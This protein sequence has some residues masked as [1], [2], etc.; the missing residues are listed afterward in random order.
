MKEASAYANA[1]AQNTLANASFGGFTLYDRST[2]TEDDY[3][4]GPAPSV[5]VVLR[6]EFGYVVAFGGAGMRETD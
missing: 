3:R 5:T 1:I 2:L 4:D 6:G